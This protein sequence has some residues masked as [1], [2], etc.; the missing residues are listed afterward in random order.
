[1]GCEAMGHCNLHFYSVNSEMKNW[2]QVFS[3]NNKGVFKICDNKNKVL[4]LFN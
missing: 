3:E 1:M 2:K 4:I